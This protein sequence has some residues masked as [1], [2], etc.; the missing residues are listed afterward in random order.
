MPLTPGFP[1]TPAPAAGANPLS[2]EPA[3]ALAAVGET[4]AVVPK[5]TL[6][7]VRAQFE[8]LAKE[9]IPLG[10]IASQV[11]CELGAYTMDMA[12]VSGQPKAELPV[13]EVAQRILAGAAPR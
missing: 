5:T 3:N 13:G 4:N 11:M 10:D 12:L 2:A 6:R 9:F 7:Q 1:L 8:Y